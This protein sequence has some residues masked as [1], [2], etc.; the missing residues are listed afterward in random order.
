[1]KPESKVKILHKPILEEFSWAESNDPKHRDDDTTHGFCETFRDCTTIVFS[2]KSADVGGS[3]YSFDSDGCVGRIGVNCDD[4]NNEWVIFEI[5]NAN[6]STGTFPIFECRVRRGSPEANLQIRGIFTTAG[7]TTIYNSTID[8]DPSEWG[9]IR[10]NLYKLVGNDTLE[11]IYIVL[12]DNPNSYAGGW[13]YA[14]VDWIRVFKLRNWAFEMSAGTDDG[15]FWNKDGVFRAEGDTTGSNWVMIKKSVSINRR[16]YPYIVYR[17]RAINGGK[18]RITI[19]SSSYYVEG[20]NSA[21]Q[22]YVK[23]WDD[24]ASTVPEAITSVQVRSSD[25]GQTNGGAEIDWIVVCRDPHELSN[26]GHLIQSVMDRGRDSIATFVLDLANPRTTRESFYYDNVERTQDEASTYNDEEYDSGWQCAC[27]TASEWPLLVGSGNNPATTDGNITTFTTSASADVQW[28]HVPAPYLD[29]AF[30]RKCKIRMS[31]S[32]GSATMKL[33]FRTSD[34]TWYTSDGWNNTNYLTRVIDLYTLC[35]GKPI[36]AIRVQIINGG[37]YSGYVD[38]IK[39]YADVETGLYM[40][41]IHGN[42][43]AVIDLS[44]DGSTFDECL[45]GYVGLVDEDTSDSILRVSGGARAVKYTKILENETYFEQGIDEACK[46]LIDELG[47]FIRPDY[48]SETPAYLWFHEIHA[49]SYWEALRSLADTVT[50]YMEITDSGGLTFDFKPPK[51]I[52]DH[53]A[54]EDPARPVMWREISDV[55]VS[56]GVPKTDWSI[57]D[58]KAVSTANSYLLHDKGIIENFEMEVSWKRPSSDAN[59]D[60]IYFFYQDPY[61]YYQIM[62]NYTGN[63]VGLRKKDGSG[64]VVNLGSLESYTLAPGET[65]IIKLRVVDDTMDLFINDEHILK[66]SDSA[67]DY[68]RFGFNPEQIVN[69]E[70]FKLRSE[71][72]AQ[73][74][75]DKKDLAGSSQQVNYDAIVNYLWVWGKPHEYSRTT[76]AEYQDQTSIDEYGISEGIVTVSNTI[77]PSL[78]KAHAATVLKESKDPAVSLGVS[79]FG[80]PSISPGDIAFLESEALQRRGKY[81]VNSVRH[82]FFVRGYFTELELVKL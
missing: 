10:K 55:S 49:V 35:E 7:E 65:Y 54:I 19:N 2:S 61:H 36:K 12:N 72:V 71:D 27:A 53:F 20:T 5:D 43:V 48:M 62:L 82:R 77:R 41:R 18:Y 74:F 8:G 23:H 59:Q 46:D 42:D 13:I 68:G 25:N 4:I 63:Q 38:F 80:N 22:V 32:S 50:F 81:L 78:L 57:S 24:F 73:T 69:I 39:I 64:G 15:V 30:Y 66:R 60:F 29:S 44:L 51:L 76:F 11:K 21:F 9:T 75:T 52:E 1:M 67:F 56:S 26:A 31:V 34:G 33:R 28:E 45:V 14:F 47:G 6:L 37:T 58:G 70:Y 79:V 40:G 16:E 3:D 17:A